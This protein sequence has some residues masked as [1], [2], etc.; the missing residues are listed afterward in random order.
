MKKQQ[1]FQQLQAK[2]Y[3]KLANSGFEDIEQPDGNLK[4]WATRPSRAD[5]VS[6]AE[7]YH[8]AQQYHQDKEFPTTLDK[9]VWGWHSKGLTN[10]QVA[11]RVGKSQG[12][13]EWHLKKMRRLFGLKWSNKY[14]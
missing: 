12:S 7:Y 2:W 3:R 10:E 9:Y 5:M 1:S 13:V 14:D 6:R 11:R 4:V 8:L